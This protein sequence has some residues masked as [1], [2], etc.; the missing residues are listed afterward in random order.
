MLKYKVVLILVLV[1][2]GGKVY[3]RNCFVSEITVLILVLVDLGGKDTVFSSS[4]I[5]RSSS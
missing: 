4:E 1:D 5:R 2:L 3:S